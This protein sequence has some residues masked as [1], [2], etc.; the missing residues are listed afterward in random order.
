MKQSALSPLVGFIL[1]MG[2]FSGILLVVFSLLPFETWSKAFDGI[3]PDGR[4]ESFT[5]VRFQVW[6]KVVR[7]FGVF[8]FLFFAGALIFPQKFHALVKTGRGWNDAFWRELK[9]DA[10]VIWTE[11]Q[12]GIKSRSDILII[13]LVVVVAVVV[14]MSNLF[15]PMEHDEAYNYNAFASFPLWYVISDY[16]VPNNHVL[17]TIVVNILTG[18]FGNHLWVMRIPTF[19]AGVYMIPA[20]YWLAKRLYDKETAVVSAVFIALF[21]ILVKYSVLARGYA[22]I[23][24]LTLL[25][26]SIGDYVRGNRNRFAWLIL[27]ILSALGFYTVPIMLIPFG[28]L[29]AWLLMS[30]LFGDIESYRSKMDFIKFYLTGGVLIGLSTGILYSPI[31]LNPSNRLFENKFI[32]PLGWDEYPSAIWFRLQN[33]WVDW[34]S[35]IPDWLVVLGVSGVL[36]GLVFHKRINRHKFPLQAAFVVSIL[37]FMILRRPDME[38]RMWTFIAAPL[39][40]WSAGG[41]IGFM[42]AVSACFGMDWQPDRVFS[43]LILTISLIYSVYII[44][45]IPARWQAKGSV[46]SAVIYLKDRLQP[47]DTVSISPAFTPQVRYYF[48]LYDIPLSFLRP[49]V[50]LERAYVF[51]RSVNWS[52]SAGDTLEAVAP[53]N[54]QGFLAI[55]PATA[56]DILQYEDLALY[57]CYPLP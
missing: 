51:V 11:A 12:S 17:L 34:V 43:R 44:P 5:L 40:I 15:I 1:V 26:L 6:L 19:I 36:F 52:A 20:G 23:G 22:I 41:L 53:R 37:S 24:L 30:L 57:E 16:H 47:G 2:I 48:D 31:L 28:A 54:N 39:L 4:F 14:R 38:T 33:T 42:K 49:S 25:I 45:T 10:R 7:S 50:K 27:V 29:Y 21:P 32:A 8:L 18:L 9:G 35:A 46:E 13:L 3:A 55:D 56:R